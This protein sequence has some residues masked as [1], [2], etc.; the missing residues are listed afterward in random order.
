[1][2]L[3]ECAFVGAPMD[4]PKILSI[5]LAPPDTITVGVIFP[6][7]VF[8]GLSD[9]VPLANMRVSVTIVPA[10]NGRVIGL[11]YETGCAFEVGVS[12]TV[13]RCCF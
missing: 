4:R 9:S 8:V 10:K 1:M 6:T 13:R 7:T 11:V 12:E 5:L 2:N 3:F